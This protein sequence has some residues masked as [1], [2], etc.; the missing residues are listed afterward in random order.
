[1]TGSTSLAPLLERFFMQRLIQQRQVSPH[2]ISSYRDTFRLLL[3]F[4][5]QR[6]HKRY[7]RLSER[8]KPQGKI[9]TAVARELVGF[10]WAALQ[11][12]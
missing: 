7:R 10:L 9:V 1:M 2:T 8:G 3:K 12:D 4:T 6:L 11:D 5:Q